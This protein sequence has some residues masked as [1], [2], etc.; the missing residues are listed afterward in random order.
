LAAEAYLTPLDQSDAIEGLAGIQ[1]VRQPQI[2]ADPDKFRRKRAHR[3]EIQLQQAEGRKRVQ[4]EGDD[5]H[6]PRLANNPQAEIDG[7]LGLIRVSG[8]PKMEPAVQ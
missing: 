3:L 7:L 2:L 8:A 6:P 5:V 1:I 4:R